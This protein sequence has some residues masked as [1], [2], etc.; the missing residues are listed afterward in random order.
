MTQRNIVWCV[1]AAAMT[2]AML[3]GTAF[4]QAPDT[5]DQ[6]EPADVT[7]RPVATTDAN[8]DAAFLSQAIEMNYAEIE[9]GKLAATRAESQRV[10]SYAAMLVKDH[11]A[12]LAKFQALERGGPAKPQLSAEHEK[13][14]MKLSGMT[15]AEFDREYIDAM[16]LG[17][18]ETL[19]MFERQA[20]SK[21]ASAP[22][23]RPNTELNKLVRET[24]PSLKKHLSQ[25]EELHK[26]LSHPK[27]KSVTP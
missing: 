16:V 6:N 17:H 25:A 22:A 7:L 19:A 24:L 8:E 27:G 26:T 15:G 21:P 5:A 13:L 20:A 3:V 1:P 18:R 11:T 12:A 4:A 9:L 2:I 14:Q 10:K 23:G